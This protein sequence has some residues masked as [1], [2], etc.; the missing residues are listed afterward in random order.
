MAAELT[1]FV[2][3]IILLL[4]TLAYIVHGIARGIS[5]Y[6]DVPYVATPLRLLPKISETLKI[7]SDSIV[8]DLGCGD[9]RLLFYCAKHFPSAKFVGIERN[10]LLVLFARIRQRILGLKNISFRR[11]NIFN[12]NF[13]DA[14]IIYA[15][16]LTAVMDRLFADDSTHR[17][18]PAANNSLHHIRLVSRAFKIS[19]RTP[20]ETIELQGVINICGEHQLH[21]Y[22]W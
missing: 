1:I 4:G 16:L 3:Q 11:E 12:A 13:S 14:T 10:M 20:I 5:G 22:E 18:A 19:G 21:V 6:M 2:L 7:R 8:Y 17:A 15:F 9:G